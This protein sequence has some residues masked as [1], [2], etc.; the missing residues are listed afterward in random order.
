LPFNS[1]EGLKFNVI[2]A[3]S[4]AGDTVTGFERFRKYEHEHS[5]AR[6][7]LILL[8]SSLVDFFFWELY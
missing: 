8:Y 1:P 4:S 2:E 3:S 6:K 7:C 5:K